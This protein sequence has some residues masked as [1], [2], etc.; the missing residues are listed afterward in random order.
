MTV[1]STPPRV[2]FAPSPTGHVH[3][4]NIRAAIFNWLFARHNHGKFLLRVEDTDLE[5]S[6]KEAIDTLLEAMDWMGLDYDE[7]IVYQTHLVQ[8]HHDAAKRLI[9]AGDAYYGK[10]E[11]G[12]AAPVYFRIP[13]DTNRFSCVRK[14]GEVS[15]DLHS[16]TPVV[17]DFT[18]M[19]YAQLSR[20]GKPMEEKATLAGFRDLVLTDA[21]G[22]NLF[23]IEGKHD[24]IRNG[25]TFTIVGAAK[26]TFTRH[27]VFYRDLVKGELAKPLD[28][29]RDFVIV[30]STNAPVFHLAN[31][32]D[33]I[34]QSI[35]H[36]IR[37][38]DHVENTYR[39]LF[40]F[41][42][43]GAVPPA[44]AHLPMIVNREGKPYSKRDGDAFVGDFKTKGFLP[45]ALFN[46]LSLLGW[47]PGDDRE[48]MSKQE[49]AD[50]FTLE[51]CS[52]SPARLDMV[53]LQ[54]L[55]ARYIA[56][57]DEEQFFEFVVPYIRSY[58]RPTIDNI[59]LQGMRKVI[60]LMRPR[61]HCG[62]DVAAWR[63]FID[64]DYE[65]DDKAMTKM[66]ADATVTAGLKSLLEGLPEHWM[67]ASV[68]H[69]IRVAE[70]AVGLDEGKLNQPVRLATT[71]LRGGADLIQ[72]LLL[73]GRECV[74][75][76]LAKITGNL[77]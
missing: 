27:E 11:D 55:N 52:S 42:C 69:A 6:T 4:G 72:T 14:V 1:T 46:Y 47:S 32:C 31:V 10:V 17:I 23:A 36:I 25:E 21:E 34:T 28:T 18:G 50:A 65:I 71:G 3:I 73:L 58:L 61:T 41:Y 15:L 76:R 68:E 5:R 2:R 43:L 22:N 29:I 19:A 20:K 66:L 74:Q 49:L 24:A 63:Y 35:T 44:Y 48:K 56:D 59:T 7:E 54:N 75:K 26:A 30:R 16:E 37:G 70:T 40:I 57:M 64:D 67:Y 39:H 62:A 77:S 60:E 51:R 12:E 8:N 9:D 53:K 13:W 38:D 45:Q 33:D